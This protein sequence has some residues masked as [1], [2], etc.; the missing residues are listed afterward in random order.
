MQMKSFLKLLFV[1]ILC[2]SSKNIHPQP[3]NTI[4]FKTDAKKL[5]E[6]SRY[7]EAIDQLNKYVSA[8]PN[9]AEG[10]NL[11]GLCYEKRGNL[12]YAVYDLRTARKISPDNSEINSNLNRVIK[13]WYK[14]LYNKIE[15]HKREIAKNS[16]IAVN[17]LEIGKCYKNLGEWDE[18]E[19]W[20]D[21]YLEKETASSDEI[22]RYSEIL[23]KNNHIAKGKPILKAYTQKHPD[24]HRLWSRYGYFTL[25]L[26]KNNIAIDAFTKSLEIRPYFKEA[27]DGLDLAKG[28][29]YIYSVNDTSSWNKNTSL[30]KQKVYAIDN[31]YRILKNKLDDYQTRFKLVEQLLLVNRLEEASQQLQILSANHSDIPKYQELIS[32]LS[33][34][35]EIYYTS[36]IKVLES[37]LSKNPV[38]K[39]ALLEIVSIFSNLNELEKSEWYLRNFLATKED[40]DVRFKL[41]Q[42]LMWQNKLCDANDEINKL[43]LKNAENKDYLLLSAQ[44]KFWLNQDLN[45]SEELFNKVITKDQKNIDAWTGIANI[46]LLKKEITGVKEIIEKL[47]T[48]N[49][50]K[51]L[52][53]SL[54][55]KLKLT[56]KRL[57]DEKLLLLLESARQSAYNED[58]KKSVKLFNEYL[59]SPDANLNIR[60]EL[61]DIYAAN[62]NIDKALKVLETLLND[63][64]DI[65]LRKKKAQ[66]LLWKGDSI[67]AL[68]NAKILLQEDPDNVEHKVMLG[69][70]YLRT[71][72]VQNA[73]MIYNELF[74]KYPDSHILKLRMNW[75]DGRGLN[76]NNF[77]VF[78]QLNPNTFYFNDNTGF[79]LFNY[80]MGIGFGIT[81]FLTLG[82]SGGHGT[83]FSNT[84]EKIFNQIK[85]NGFIKFSDHVNS[86]VSFGRT[87]FNTKEKENIFDFSFSIREN[88]IYNLSAFINFNDAVFI[89]FSP[90]LVSERLNTYY[91]GL[92]GDYKFKN[93]ILLSGKY[94]H[95]TT[96]EKNDGNQF[97]CRL[98]KRFFNS[99]NIGY[100]YYYFS[101]R[102][103]TNLYWSPK[104]FEAHSIW[105]DWYLLQ[106]ENV[107]LLISGKVGWIPRDNFILGEISPSFSYKILPTLKI[108]AKFFAG[109]S[110]RSGLAY[111]SSSF[112]AGLFWTF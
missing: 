68:K 61:A 59:S 87:F 58:Y 111:R 103:Y 41:A 82:F 65:E 94:A 15:G 79:E 34:Q 53:T 29:G 84:D 55:E 60:S 78:T 27:L 80:G 83:L 99:L 12:E 25:W 7:G 3:D 57:N 66:L 91:F 73:K 30:P 70:A 102:E 101:M 67:A 45:T 43:T 13:D 98:G 106:D 8:N 72:Q 69:D 22:I 50:E 108:E 5:M 31:Y 105:T 75:I 54:D 90:F 74:D 2:L 109:N 89:L 17:Y 100:E 1:F 4:Q 28:K 77:P 42:C 21:L 110:Y 11:R 39:K 56:E 23:A 47:I 35:R 62:G 104:N 19:V 96:S 52:T 49:A 97:Q 71:G 36:R 37:E 76:R 107:S 64:N 63:N 26:G 38:N 46:K 44:I 81:D 95:I 24:D 40:D 88:N 14:L 51:Y 93:G 9:D 20:Y 16:S 10:F 85:G 6:A 86:S 18:A 32:K 112:Q 33:K 48:L 92:N